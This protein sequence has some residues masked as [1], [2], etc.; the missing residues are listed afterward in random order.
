[1]TTGDI[2]S[3]TGD[4]AESSAAAL[5]GPTPTQDRPRI[6]ALQYDVFLSYSR[7]DLDI[8]DKIERDLETF[9]LPRGIRK[10]LGHRHLNV[11]RDISDITGNQVET[12]LEEKLKQSRTLVVLCSPAAR[13]STSVKLSALSLRSRSVSR[14]RS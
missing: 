4:I 2:E 8:T 1:M 14:A 6:D 12:A 13:R 3:S 5:S 9:P 7:V 10:R 11:F